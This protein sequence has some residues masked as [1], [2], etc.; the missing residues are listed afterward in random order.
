MENF[1]DRLKLLR[2]E[3][4]LSQNQLA[5]TLKIAQSRISEWEAG[6]SMPSA[7]NLIILAKYFKCSVDYL[8]GLED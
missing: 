3:N 5:K 8:L 4:N 1:A 6:F 7:E 2:I